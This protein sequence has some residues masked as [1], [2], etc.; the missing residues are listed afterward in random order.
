[1]AQN[2]GSSRADDSDFQSQLFQCQSPG[3]ERATPEFRKIREVL[4][5]S[6]SSFTGTKKKFTEKQDARLHL[7]LSCVA[8][9]I[10]PATASVLSFLTISLPT[11]S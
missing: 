3:K 4:I 11:S 6:R 9:Y 10:L 2:L 8:H 5:I 1:M 7:L